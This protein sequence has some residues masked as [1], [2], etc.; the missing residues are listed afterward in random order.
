MHTKKFGLIFR[1]CEFASVASGLT[2]K[3]FSHTILIK[4]WKISFRKVVRVAISLSTYEVLRDVKWRFFV[5]FNFKIHKNFKTV[6]IYNYC[7]TKN[8]IYWTSKPHECSKFL[9]EKVTQNFWMTW[10]ARKKMKTWNICKETKLK[11][12]A[13]AEKF[14]SNCSFREAKKKFSTYLKKF[15]L[16]QFSFICKNVILKK[17]LAAT[18]WTFTIFTIQKGKNEEEEKQTRK[19]GVKPL[20]R[21]VSIN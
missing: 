9:L 4:F 5:L 18:Q 3:L 11:F 12:L 10:N 6:K 21:N 15:F 7:N 1:G 17:F 16:P 2:W 20:L 13:G 14:Y 19:I 8:L